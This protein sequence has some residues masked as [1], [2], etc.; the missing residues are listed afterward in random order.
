LDGKKCLHNATSSPTEPAFGA[1]GEEAQ[2]F[3]ED[4]VHVKMLRR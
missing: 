1:T 3:E 2:W 4:S